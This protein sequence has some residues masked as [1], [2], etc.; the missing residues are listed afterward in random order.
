MAERDAQLLRLESLSTS[1]KSPGTPLP[2]LTLPPIPTDHETLLKI[3]IL[4]S[5]K[6]EL[7]IENERLSER[8]KSKAQELEELTIEMDTM[9]NDLDAMSSASDG[10]GLA[11]VCTALCCTCVVIAF[12]PQCVWVIREEEK[13]F[14]FLIS[15]LLL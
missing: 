2:T 5:F 12:D 3:K 1:Q 7:Q 6:D 8:L 15:F 10:E 4:E 11:K 13:L 9:R 14:I